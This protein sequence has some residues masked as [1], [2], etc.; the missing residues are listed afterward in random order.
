MT[1]FF[2]ASLVEVS[3]SVDQWMESS[4]N[5]Q[6]YAMAELNADTRSKLLLFFRCSSSARFQLR[7]IRSSNNED[8]SNALAKLIKEQE[9]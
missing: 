6:P 7:G 3:S 2:N 4:S 1:I 5:Q 8:N 9:P